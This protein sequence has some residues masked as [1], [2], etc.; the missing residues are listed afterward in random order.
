MNTPNIVNI[1]RGASAA[2]EKA[3]AGKLR[4]LLDD[5][6]WLEH[7]PV[8]RFPSMHERGFDLRVALKFRGR[9]TTQL[10]V[11]CKADP[12]PS[13]FPSAFVVT[14]A[15]NPPV[16]VLAAPF[17]SPRM[18]EVC[19]GE[20]W[21]WFDLAGNCR[22][23]IPG[24]LHLHQT[25]ARPVHRPPRPTANLAT[26]EAGRIIR[27]LLH[28]EHA[29]TRWTQRY[30]AEHFGKM[31]CPTPQPSLG[32]VNKV[33][34]HL[35]NEAFIEKAPEGGFRLCDPVRLLF[36]WRDAYR[37]DRHDRRSYFSLLQGN[38]LREA[39]AV[40]GARTGGYTAYAAFSAAEFQAP[41]VRQ[42]K[43]WLYIREQDMA[44]FEELIAA[45]P[46][47]SGENLVVLIPNDEGVFYLGDGGMMSDHRLACTSA[48]Q[49]YVDLWHCG[50]RGQ[51]AAEALLEQ[52]L[53]PAWKA[54]GLKL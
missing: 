24:L 37:F 23:D 13:Q 20:G 3:L 11:Q 46:V 34:R 43:T 12:R 6:G 39:L 49:T 8:A 22:L 41:H 1:H 21:S 53:K 19:K 42:P 29:G 50:G 38:K 17:I 52:R 45:K 7:G 44:L 15:S 30:L 18:A 26:P 28:P 47:D 27:A 33:V 54:E 5:I 40:L 51:E 10:W 25:G 16:P 31:D 48:V 36:A 9:G 14:E 35:L 4:E 32:L 2:L